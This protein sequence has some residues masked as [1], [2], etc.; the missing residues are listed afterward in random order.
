MKKAQN[1]LYKAGG[2]MVSAG[3]FSDRIQCVRHST[4]RP[5]NSDF[6]GLLVIVVLAQWQAGGGCPGR[7]CRESE[8]QEAA[9]CLTRAGPSTLLQP[10]A[11][12]LQ[13]T[14][15]FLSPCVAC[16]QGA[17]MASEF[18]VRWLAFAVFRLLAQ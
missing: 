1:L 7:T 5:L 13:R 4:A 8:G 9:F 18:C 6:R 11:A 12:T 14:C 17:P 16:C 15:L 10:T 3:Y 2:T